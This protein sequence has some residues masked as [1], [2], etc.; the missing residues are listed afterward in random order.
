VEKKYKMQMKCLV[1]VVGM[2]GLAVG[3]DQQ[4]CDIS[5][6]HTMCRYSGVG[7]A[8]GALSERGL[9]EAEVKEVL[10]YHNRL[11]SRVAVGST[12]QPPA[13]NMLQLTW[14]PELARVAQRL[15]DQ[16]KFSHDCPDCRRVKRFKVGQNLYQSFT[17]RSSE[18]SNWVKAI[19]SWFTEIKLFPT[20]SVSSYKFSP[21]TGHYSQMMWAKTSKIGCG[22]TAFR[23][24][25]FN[26]RLYV[27]NY[28][29]TGN[30]LRQQV[31]KIGKA[32]SSCSGSCSTEFPGLCTA[33]PSTATACNSLMCMI[34]KPVNAA[35]G[36]VTAAGSMAME[37][38][39]HVGGTAMQVGHEVGH[40]AMNTVNTIT[41]LVSSGGQTIVDNGIRPVNS[42]VLNGFN[43]ATR[44]FFGPIRFPTRFFNGKKK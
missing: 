15:A 21:A 33:A 32:C 3:Q 4:Y 34:H 6:S 41:N 44:P 11:R 16:C 24:G 22:V 26:T 31:Y 14:D 36:T 7:P 1:L 23:S 27:C 35:A 28:G 2:V 19:D 38:A 30:I 25:R 17:T 12:S 40:A 8:C 18:K 39:H 42:L 9:G 10:D 43:F 13:A 20:T 29:Q 5:P 37:T